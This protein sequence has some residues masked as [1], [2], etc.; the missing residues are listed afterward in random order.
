M[1]YLNI[2]LPAS[3]YPA[4]SMH[5]EWNRNRIPTRDLRASDSRVFRSP[6]VPEPCTRR[7]ER[8]RKDFPILSYIFIHQGAFSCPCAHTNGPVAW[9]VRL[10]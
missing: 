3:E 2:G 7:F 9:S 8:I 10:S 1:S 5:H 4:G 6:A